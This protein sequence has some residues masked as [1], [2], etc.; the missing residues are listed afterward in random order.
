M[1]VSIIITNYNYAPFLAQAIESALQQEGADVEVIVVDDGSTDDSGRI[2]EG[3]AGRITAVCQA[4]AGQSAAAQTG[5][6]RSS[7]DA[8]IFLDADDTLY[9]HAARLH[10]EHL[11]DRGV[12]RSS[13]YLDVCDRDLRPIGRL[14]PH[15]LS[16]SGDYRQ[17]YELFG[18]TACRP[19]FTSGNAWSRGFLEKIM[20]LPQDKV[21]GLDG[22]LTAVDLLYGRIESIPAS[23]GRYRVHNSNK[24]PVSYRFDAAYLG[25]RLERW[26]RRVAYSVG[27]AR[28]LGIEVDPDDWRRRRNWQF[29]LAARALDLLEPGHPGPGY[30]ESVMSPVRSSPRVGPRQVGL[31]M[32]M[33]ASRLLPP[34]VELKLAASLLGSTWGHNRSRAQGVSTRNTAGRTDDA[35]A[36]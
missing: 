6:E 21:V 13:G 11:S 36:G 29:T 17:E 24:G 1:L 3:Y 23:V 18:P 35:L 32:L 25:N 10:A 16:P 4:N 9:P 20:P 26:E 19:A 34:R 7:G 5:F 28:R 12:T 8:V 14:L 27:H 30:L 33:A 31:S 22:Y 15:R 2:I